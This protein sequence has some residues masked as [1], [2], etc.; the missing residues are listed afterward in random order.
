M[1]CGVWCVCTS[2]PAPLLLLRLAKRLHLHSGQ[3]RRRHNAP[4]H[5][6]PPH[7]RRLF[8]PASPSAP[9]P[10]PTQARER[11]Q[12]EVQR[13]EEELVALAVRAQETEGALREYKRENAKFYEVKERYKGALAG[14]E[15]EVQVR[16]AGAG[17]AVGVRQQLAGIDAQH[18]CVHSWSCW[19]QLTTALPAPPALPLRRR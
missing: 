6:P 9:A 13:K 14:L 7:T 18:L 16:A 1:E 10:L 5:A 19:C 3:R 15:A 2:L 17:G 8:P 4:A 12:A 11:A